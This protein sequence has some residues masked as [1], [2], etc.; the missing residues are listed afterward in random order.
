VDWETA[1]DKILEL[2]GAV[3]GIAGGAGFALDHIPNLE[4]RNTLNSYLVT[5]SNGTKRLNLWF[6]QRT[7]ISVARGGRGTGLPLGYAEYTDVFT[8]SGFYN[9]TGQD[10]YVAFQDLVE[11]VIRTLTTNLTLDRADWHTSPPRVATLG[12][13][14]LAREYCHHVQITISVNRPES[15]AWV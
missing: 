9:Y 8:V 5:L 2:V 6:V 10:S 4:D 12:Y 15:T 11:R 7:D 1:S 3:E 13:A 14:F